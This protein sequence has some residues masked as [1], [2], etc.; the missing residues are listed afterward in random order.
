[1]N[2]YLLTRLDECGYDECNGFVIAARSP[3]SARK[4]A[5]VNS[6]DESDRVMRP[7]WSDTN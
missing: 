7:F 6:G 5:E 4:I 3:V 2:L 1:M